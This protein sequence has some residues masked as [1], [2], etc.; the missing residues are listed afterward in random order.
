MEIGNQIL[1]NPVSQALQLIGDRWTIFILRDAFLGRHRFNEFIKYSVQSR[2]TLTNRL[3]WLIEK[4]ILYKSKYMEKPPRYEYK[5]TDKGV[6]LYPWALMIWQWESTWVDQETSYVPN[7]LFHNVKTPHQLKPIL[8]C[9]CC[10]QA[11][12]YSDIKTIKL[13]NTH[14]DSELETPLNTLS[15]QRRS[16]KTKADAKDKSLGHIVDIIGD[17]WSNLVVAACFFGIRRF[18]DFQDE[19][20]ISTNILSNRLKKLIDLQI[21]ARAK[22]Q[23]SPKRFEYVLTEKGKSLYP[24]T[25]ALRQWVIDHLEPMKS[26][27]SLIHTSCGNELNVDAVCSDCGEIPKVNEVSFQTS[28]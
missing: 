16:A 28:K 18:D 17:R 1:K 21:L 7:A 23:D 22:Y 11:V 15:T 25:L 8:V 24:Q 20:K 27:F 13:E 4:D 5:L 9:R 2:V 14:L 10:K 26:S 3:E 19:L 12:T 6:G